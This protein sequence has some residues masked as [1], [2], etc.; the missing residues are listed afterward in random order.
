MRIVIY[1]HA[2]E[3]LNQK[4]RNRVMI[5]IK[6]C[7]SSLCWQWIWCFRWYH[8]QQ[9]KYYPRK[10][11]LDHYASPTSRDAYRDRRLTT[12]FELW[13]EIFLC[14]DMFP[15]EDSKTVSVCP[16][17]RLSVCPSVC[18]HPEKRYNHSFVNISPTLV[19]DT[20]MERSSWV[21]HQGNPKMWFFFFSKKFEI[22]ILTFDKELKSP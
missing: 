18:P 6:H 10:F 12:N 20:S 8:H 17:V 13:V 11:L 14:A 21:L 22:R 5:V 19:I 15:Y 4:W 7:N 3:R 16:S 2:G 1:L 9:N